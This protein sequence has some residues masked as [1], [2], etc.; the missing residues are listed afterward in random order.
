M[1]SHPWWTRETNDYDQSPFKRYQ[2]LCFAVALGYSAPWKRYLD[3][4]SIQT[5]ACGWSTEVRCQSPWINEKLWSRLYRQRLR[6]FLFIRIWNRLFLYQE[7]FV[8]LMMWDMMTSWFQFMKKKTSSES[9]F[10]PNL[11]NDLLFPW[12]KW[13]FF[14]SPPQIQTGRFLCLHLFLHQLLNPLDDYFIMPG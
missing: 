5:M 14:R 11:I 9:C 10:L 3:A 1:C 2:S 6:F 7:I 8:D 13:F 12:S 4:S